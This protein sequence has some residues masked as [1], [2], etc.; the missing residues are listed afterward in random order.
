MIMKWQYFTLAAALTVMACQGTGEPKK[1]HEELPMKN[2]NNT[3]TSQKMELLVLPAVFEQKDVNKMGHYVLKN[4]F[5][6]E[7]VISSHFTIEKLVDEKWVT[8]PLSEMLAFEDITY[9]IPPK[10]SKEFALA[11]S[12]ILKDK[13]TLK[14]QYRLVKEAW[15]YGHDTDKKKLTARFEIK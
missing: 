1:K 3:N 14:G 5:D 4:N 2:E 10:K 6:K 9:A 7:L 13:A 12:S 8:V 11:L 15:L